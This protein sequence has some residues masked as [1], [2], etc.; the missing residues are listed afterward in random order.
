[1]RNKLER[2]SAA[3][4]LPQVRFGVVPLGAGLPRA[5]PYRFLDHR[6]QLVQFDTY[7]AELSLTRPDEIAAAY[8]RA[9]ERLTALAVYGPR[10]PCSDSYVTT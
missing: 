7:T 2:L 10:G 8:A 6:R 5:T 1:M 4:N 9:F 3:I